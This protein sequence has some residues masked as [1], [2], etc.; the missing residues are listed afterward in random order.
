M[1]ESYSDG[2]I[3]ETSEVDGGRNREMSG[4]GRVCERK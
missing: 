2:G 1:F 4:V 3:K